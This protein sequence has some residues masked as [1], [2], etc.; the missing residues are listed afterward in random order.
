VQ[1][2]RHQTTAEGRVTLSIPHSWKSFLGPS[3]SGVFTRAS[4]L[5]DE[6]EPA[7]MAPIPTSSLH[8]VVRVVIR[9]TEMAPNR[10]N[11]H[12][13]RNQ[14]SSKPAKTVSVGRDRPDFG[15]VRPRFKSLAPD[16]MLNTNPS[17]SLD[18]M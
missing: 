9:A 15:S 12:R 10:S 8:V 7:R 17:P 6:G 4:S 5:M 18:L 13:R 16:K 2:I 1:R 14:F 3:V 11:R